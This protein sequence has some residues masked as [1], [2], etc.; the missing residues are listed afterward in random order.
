MVAGAGDAN[1]VIT[2]PLTIS[3]SYV[4]ETMQD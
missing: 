1:A 4:N 3:S 2:S